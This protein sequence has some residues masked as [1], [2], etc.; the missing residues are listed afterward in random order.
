MAE[1]V[2]ALRAAGVRHLLCQMSF[3]YLAHDKILASM[4]RFGEH[5]RPAF[6]AP[7]DQVS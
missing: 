3:G 6:G 7:P 5:V 2:A 1:Q 4:R